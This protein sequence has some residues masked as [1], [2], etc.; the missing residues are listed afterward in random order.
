MQ[1][2]KTPTVTSSFWPE[3]KEKRTSVNQGVLESS[4]FFSF[5]LL[6]QVQLKLPRFVWQWGGERLKS[7]DKREKPF[8]RL[9]RLIKEG[10]GSWKLYQGRELE[11]RMSWFC[12]LMSSV[13]PG[14]TP[15]ILRTELGYCPSPK[16]AC[17]YGQDPKNHSKAFAN[18]TYI[19]TSANVRQERNWLSK[20]NQV[21]CLPKQTKTKINI[22]RRILTE[23]RI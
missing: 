5:S 17:I 14:F 8:I 13:S 7:S 20:F 1:I 9:D 19:G 23:F 22:L 18:R 12:M 3:H 10:P 4:H 11:K 2:A 15:K 6:L 16:M 21:D